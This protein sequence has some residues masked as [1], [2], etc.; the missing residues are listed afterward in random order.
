M[1]SFELKP[2]SEFSIPQTA[3]LLTCGFE[4]YLVPININDA[5]LLTMSRRDGIDLNES[6]ILLSDEEPIGVALIARRGSL[7]ASRLAAIGIVSHARNGGVGTWAMQNLID[8]ARARGDKEW[9]SKSLSKIR[10]A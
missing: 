9:C 10:R 2:A 4:G 3:D 1:P 6:C 7:R 5:A 8:Q